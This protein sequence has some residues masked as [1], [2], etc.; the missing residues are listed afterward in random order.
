MLRTQL[1]HPDILRAL[2]TSGH[3]GK[4][5]IADGN[6]PFSTLANPHAPRV[7]LNLSPGIAS[8]TDVVR[9][10]L[11]VVPVE[12]AE[13]PMTADGTAPDIH[14]DFRALLGDDVPLKTLAPKEFY[15]AACGSD[16]ALVIATAEQRL[17]GNIIL[18][19]GVVKPA[20]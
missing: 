10:L 5:F 16:V 19:I 13:V 8:A 3:T 1:L 12:S 11:S 15:A 17:Y 2:A 18:T 9:A 14:A 20:P 6:Y 7:Y 4:V